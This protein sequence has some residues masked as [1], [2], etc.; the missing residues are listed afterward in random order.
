MSRARLLE[1]ES[2]PEVSF[3]ADAWTDSDDFT[4]RR[5]FCDGIRDHDATGGLTRFLEAI[6]D[7]AIVQWTQVYACTLLR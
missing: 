5:L 6:D 1:I 3:P 7:N 2:K 4:H